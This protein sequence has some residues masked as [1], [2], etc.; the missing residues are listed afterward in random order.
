[1]KLIQTKKRNI[2]KTKCCAITGSGKQCKRSPVKG[3]LCYQ[4]YELNKKV[5][6][7]V[8]SY[9]GGLLQEVPNTPESL[10]G[11]A[12]DRWRQCCQALLEHNQLK[13]VYLVD[14]LDMI[15]AEQEY[16]TLM[17]E[18][19]NLAGHEYLNTYT[20]EAGDSGNQINGLWVARRDL[21]KKIDN[22]RK[23]YWMLPDGH[24]K[25]IKAAEILPKSKG[26]QSRMQKVKDW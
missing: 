19:G 14:L 25:L 10:D 15:L 5:Q 16:Q 2:D 23:N 22:Y 8:T 9:P 24:V 18:I 1:M 4:H 11:H 20:T 7:H 3:G 17:E 12:A 26:R 21:E 13:G 6:K